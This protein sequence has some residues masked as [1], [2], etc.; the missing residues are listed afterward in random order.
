M[1]DKLEMIREEEEVVM[2]PSLSLSL[3]LFSYSTALWT[4]AADP[5]YSR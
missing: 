3:S 4:L 1:N 2:P 5:I